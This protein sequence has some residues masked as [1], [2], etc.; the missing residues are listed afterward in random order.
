MALAAGRTA[1][2]TI[3]SPGLTSLLGV[4]RIGPNTVA[5]V[6][7]PG[8]GKPPSPSG[9]LAM[10]L[11]TYLALVLFGAAQGLLGTFY[12]SA[13]P[14]PLASIGFDLAI[15]A[16]CVLGGWGLGRPSGGLAPAAGWLLATFILASGTSG[17]SV[18][19]TANG[20][21]EWFLF[22]G[23]ASA[24]A[25]VIVAFTVWSKTALARRSRP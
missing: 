24:T 7:E 13:G 17:G 11:V 6:T 2:R 21:G 3:C 23:A 12:Y 25:G 10:T 14:A 20:A 16:T 5:N 22:G 4:N 18:L 1:G 15:L 19:I 8:S 9:D